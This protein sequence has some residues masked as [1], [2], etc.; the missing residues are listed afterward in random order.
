MAQARAEVVEV[1]VEPVVPVRVGGVDAAHR[2]EL[3]VQRHRVVQVLCPVRGRAAHAVGRVQ[4]AGGV[5]G[6]C[7]LEAVDA[8]GLDE[9]GHGDVLQRWVRALGDLAGDLRRDDIVGHAVLDHAGVVGRGQE[10]EQAVVHAEHVLAVLARVVEPRAGDL[11]KLTRSVETLGR[12]RVGRRGVHL[13]IQLAGR[14]V[15]SWGAVEEQGLVVAVPGVGLLGERV[16]GVR[17]SFVM[18]MDLKV[19]VFSRQYC[20]VYIIWYKSMGYI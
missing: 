8:V 6:V 20:T 2:V 5:A 3:R 7:R 12:K 9:G 10:I 13:P 16:G 18:A 14:A 4:R 11:R 15:W 17:G 1:V 19:R